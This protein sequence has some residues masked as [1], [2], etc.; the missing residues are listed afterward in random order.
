MTYRILAIAALVCGPALAQAP[1]QLQTTPLSPNE[2]PVK[3]LRSVASSE[4]NTSERQVIG[5]ERQVMG[6][7]AT[8]IMGAGPA[9]P[10]EDETTRAVVHPVPMHLP[11]LYNGTANGGPN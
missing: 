4:P 1:P 6:W 7:S 10:L 2:A 5:S 8:S 11:S 3:T 9:Q